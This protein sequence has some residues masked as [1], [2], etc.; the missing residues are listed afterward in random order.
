LRDSNPIARA[1]FTGA[2]RL[3]VLKTAADEPLYGRSLMKSLTAHGA[4]ISPGTLYPTLHQLATRGL[5]R[6]DDRPVRGRV[7]RYY[8]LTAR[9]HRVLRDALQR[10][11]SLR[12][13]LASPAR[14]APRRAR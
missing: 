8:H 2:V 12:E 11:R 7:R 3:L 5:L 9:G 10:T 14:I 6:R 1:F 4:A 13:A